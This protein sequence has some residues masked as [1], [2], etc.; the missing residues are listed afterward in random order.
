MKDVAH[1]KKKK[2]NRVV[3]HLTRTKKKLVII[4]FK[5]YEMQHNMK[6]EVLKGLLHLWKVSKDVTHH[7]EPKLEKMSKA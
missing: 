6:P 5:I 1:L 4:G 3:T 2:K 7:T